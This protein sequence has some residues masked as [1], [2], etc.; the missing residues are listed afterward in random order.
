MPNPNNTDQARLAKL[1]AEGGSPVAIANL[2]KKL[3]VSSSVAP[4]NINTAVDPTLT[5]DQNNF[6]Q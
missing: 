6:E 5:T 1:I 4:T 2:Q 3:G